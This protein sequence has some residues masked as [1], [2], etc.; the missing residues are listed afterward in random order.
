MHKNYCMVFPKT[1]HIGNYLL[2]FFFQKQRRQKTIC[3]VPWY[4]FCVF[5]VFVFVLVYVCVYNKCGC[6]KLFRVKFPCVLRS[7][8][9][10]I[11]SCLFVV[12]SNYTL[13]WKYSGFIFLIFISMCWR[14]DWAGYSCPILHTF[15][16]SFNGTRTTSFPKIC[17]DARIRWLTNATHH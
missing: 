4:A 6:V 8:P 12:A 14:V 7:E 13:V 15:K 11:H 9:H 10:F 1:F 17:P 16:F 2:G 3:S 5:Y